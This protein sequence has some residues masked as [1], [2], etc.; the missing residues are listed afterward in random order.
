MEH[1]NIPDGELHEPKGA[2]TALEGTFYKSD[3]SGSGSWGKLTDSNVEGM[4]PNTPAGRRLTTDGSGGFSTLPPDIDSAEVVDSE[5]EETLAA[6]IADFE[7][8]IAALENA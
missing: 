4:G 3:G 5:K 7:A 1:R 6:I 8:R 2:A